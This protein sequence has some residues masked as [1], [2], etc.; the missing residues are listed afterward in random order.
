MGEKLD[1]ESW[2]IFA[3][4]ND[5]NNKKMYEINIQH[6]EQIKHTKTIEIMK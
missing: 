1:S 5:K 3:Q 4:E 6:N 2:K